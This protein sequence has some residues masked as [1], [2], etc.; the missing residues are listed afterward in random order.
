M[1]SKTGPTDK[2]LSRTHAGILVPGLQLQNYFETF[3]FT[4]YLY[5][6]F[7]QKDIHMLPNMEE[8]LAVHQRCWFPHVAAAKMQIPSHSLVILL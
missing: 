6:T 5:P 7:L 8:W 4:A 1:H 3:H 2:K